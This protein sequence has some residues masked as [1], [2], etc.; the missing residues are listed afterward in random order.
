L[1]LGGCNS[2]THP[3]QVHDDLAKVVAGV[4]YLPEKK[5]S[6]PFFF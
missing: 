2:I 3:P 5:Q 4:N 6:E 1:N